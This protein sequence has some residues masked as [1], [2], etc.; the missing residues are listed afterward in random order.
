MDK[1][2]INDI[3]E[4]ISAKMEQIYNTAVTMANLRL[5]N[6]YKDTPKEWAKKQ[7]NEIAALKRDVNTL[8]KKEVKPLFST[9][10]T[11]LLL[12]YALTRSNSRNLALSDEELANIIKFQYAYT[13]ASRMLTVLDEMTEVIQNLV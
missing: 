12:A 8:V 13:G 10:E 5:L 4:L 2:T 6:H 11:A 3:S 9:I 7:R 1:D